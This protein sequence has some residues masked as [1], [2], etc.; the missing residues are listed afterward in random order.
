VDGATAS[1]PTARTTSSTASAPTSRP[2]L[3]PHGHRPVPDLRP[4]EQQAPHGPY[5]HHPGRRPPRLLRPHPRLGEMTAPFA[6][7]YNIADYPVRPLSIRQGG[8]PPP[9][10]GRR[11]GRQHPR[12]PLRQPRID[13]LDRIVGR[14]GGYEFWRG[15]VEPFLNAE[16]ALWA[17]RPPPLQLRR[18]GLRLFPRQEPPPLLR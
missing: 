6:G 16:L 13:R 14:A 17:I 15:V 5:G 4:G 11:P 12:L 18:P 2:D 3:R 1:S 7:I 10:P 9:C 8:P